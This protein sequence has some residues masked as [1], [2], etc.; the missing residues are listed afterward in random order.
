MLSFEFGSSNLEVRMCTPSKFDIRN[1]LYVDCVEAVFRLGIVG[2]FNNNLRTAKTLV[3][4]VLCVTDRFMTIFYEG[5]TT[6]SALVFGSVINQLN[7]ALVNT[8]HTT[9]KDNEILYKL[10]TIN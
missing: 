9:N 7:T 4:T 2:G 6:G 5:C 3:N 10:I 8:I 1:S